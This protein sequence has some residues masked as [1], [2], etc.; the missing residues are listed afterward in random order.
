MP[1]YAKA[2]PSFTPAPAGTHA[3]VCVDVIDMGDVVSEFNGKKKTQH[4]IRIVWQ[5]DELR[6]DG[7]RFTVVAAVPTASTK[8]PRF[9]AIW[10][11]GAS[12]RLLRT[13]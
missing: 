3:A 2:S 4:K 7:K 8:R 6:D 9:A 12:A 13:S 1:I 11:A 5:L 10:R